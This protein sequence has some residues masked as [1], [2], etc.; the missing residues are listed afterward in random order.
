MGVTLGRIVEFFDAGYVPHAKPRVLDIGCSN[1]HTMTKEQLVAFVRARNDVWE[2]ASLERWAEYAA[3]GG[4]Y[5]SEIGGANGAWLGDLLT[6]AGIPY[7]AF[8]IFPGYKTELLDLNVDSPAPRHLNAYDVVFNFGT[9]EHLIGQLNAFKVIHDVTAP[10]GVIYHDLPMNGYLDHGYFCYNPMLF[11]ELAEANGYELLRLSFT[12]S[13]AGESIARTFYAKYADRPYLQRRSDRAADWETTTIPTNS[14]SVIVRKVADRPFR[15]SLEVSTTVGDVTSDIGDRYG[16]SGP[17]R[18]EQ[19]AAIQRVDA[20]L[21]RLGD[22]TLTVDEIMGG[23]N[24]YLAAEIKDE[25]PLS[26]ERR[27]LRLWKERGDATPAALER[28]ER[29]E[30]LLRQRRPV[31]KYVGETPPADD[32]ALDGVE[33]AFPT[34]EDPSAELPRLLAAYRAYDEKLAV[35]LFPERLEMAALS[36]LAHR[37]STRRDKDLV[38]RLSARQSMPERVDAMLRRLGDPGLSLEEIMSLYDEYV[39]SGA[40]APFPLSL[41]RRALR[42]HEERGLAT[43]SMRERAAAVDA[44]LRERYPVLKYAG[45]AAPALDLA[46]DGVEAAIPTPS[47][48]SAELARLLSA[49]RA[50][51]ERLA[52]ELFPDRLEAAAL[53]ALICQD[54]EGKDK[55]LRVRASKRQRDMAGRID[56]MLRRLGDPALTLEEILDLHKD[57][58]GSGFTIPFPLSLERRALHLYKERDDMPPS[59]RE[60][61]ERIEKLMLQRFP[62]LKHASGADSAGDLALDGVEAHVATPEDPTAALPRLLSAYR[63]YEEKLA[64]ELFPKRLEAA[65]LVALARRDAERKDKDLFIRLGALMAEI[66]PA[67]EIEAL[68]PST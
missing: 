68:R 16:A 64:V 41:E 23:Y 46:L 49:Y 51:D 13:L 24:A 44:L 53:A 8:D 3:L 55:D 56:A 47:D 61:A 20:L 54:P 7:H 50:Y 12:G 19:E 34:P 39:A 37:D 27:A 40:A 52:V 60:R 30:A 48:P 10:G 35:E 45:D 18:R 32:L 14:I 4:H 65:A 22:P 59:A 66:T 67:L 28:A 31:L 57:F 26:L 17:R 36:A 1:V 42:I 38:V 11:V 33:E 58:L 2:K 5:D 6:R 25:F 63:A 9:T 15:A 62:L 43:P 21:R 29:V